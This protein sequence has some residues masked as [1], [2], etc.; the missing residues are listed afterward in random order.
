MR[1]F[2]QTFG[3]R[4]TLGYNIEL[5][6]PF[7][8]FN[9]DPSQRDLV[10]GFGERKARPGENGWLSSYS[11]ML[12]AIDDGGVYRWSDMMKPSKAD[13]GSLM[14]AALLDDAAYSSGIIGDGLRALGEVNKESSNLSGGDSQSNMSNQND[15]SVTD[16][17][18][19]AGENNSNIDGLD[20]LYSNGT[21]TLQTFNSTADGV[22]VDDFI[23][24]GVTSNTS[25]PEDVL[26]GEESGQLTDLAGTNISTNYSDSQA[27]GNVSSLIEYT[28]VPE[29]NGFSPLSLTNASDI[30]SENVTAENETS[31]ASSNMDKISDTEIT[32]ADGTGL[33][34]GQKGKGS[35][36]GV[37]D[38]PDTGKMVLKSNRVRRQAPSSSPGRSGSPPPWAMGPQMSIPSSPGARGPPPNRPNPLGLPPNRPNSLGLPP[39]RPNSRGFPMPTRRPNGQSPRMSGSPFGGNPN[40]MMG[41]PQFPG[42]GSQPFG[43]QQQLGSPRGQQFPPGMMPQRF[44]GGVQSTG[45]PTRQPFGG[46]AG[47]QMGQNPFSQQSQNLFGQPNQNPFAQGGQNPFGQQGQSPFGQSGQNPFGQPDQSPPFGRSGSSPFG[48]PNQNPFGQSGQN[49]FGQTSQNPFGQQS[50]NPFGSQSQNPFG[51]PSQNPFGRQNQSPFGQPPRSPFGPPNRDPFGSESSFPMPGAGE[52]PEGG[53]VGIT[54][55]ESL[56]S[57][58]SL[59]TGEI[60]P[61]LELKPSPF[62][63]L[64][65]LP[66]GPPSSPNRFGSSGPRSPP[67]RGSP[68]GSSGQQNP[69]GQPSGFPGA[70]QSMGFGQPNQMMGGNPFQQ[71]QQQ[72]SPFGGFPGSN[73]RFGF[74]S[75]MPGMSSQF[76]QMGGFPG[77]SS[78]FGQGRFGSLPGMSPFMG[79]SQFG[80]GSRNGM[81]PFMSG[82]GSGSSMSGF[83]GMGGNPFMPSSSPFGRSSSFPSPMNPFG[84][85]MP[86]MRNPL[87][88]RS[89][90]PFSSPFSSM[91]AGFPGMMDMRG[92]SGGRSMGPPMGGF[93]T[94]PIGSRSR[95]RS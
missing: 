30:M 83:P 26:Y 92:M 52:G 14:L 90:S 50:Q 22:D 68:F 39:N 48:Q 35:F 84:S 49:Q 61:D 1:E 65:S 3:D 18:K 21:D 9:E 87:S 34:I 76:G 59:P 74:P 4:Q 36:L 33:L 46:P 40:P 95:S 81:N 8:P 29:I 58:A 45:G 66:M 15:S 43:G 85:S 44:P 89:M 55:S 57:P 10:P 5:D 82:S 12:N 17:L 11:R 71:Q 13:A 91:R 75:G 62:A 19:T 25:M 86:G 64:G 16:V 78:Q 51:Q 37:S 47:A 73:S 7:Q 69:F 41:G 77:M 56:P 6:D 70:P 23:D 27:E 42:A 20:S 24:T 53:P 80:S 72:Q 79:N 38:S 88:S 2:E 32:G 60:D 63:S 67:A 94:R 93:P 28:Q 54:P 31:T